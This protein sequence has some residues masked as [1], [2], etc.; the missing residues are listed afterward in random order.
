MNCELC[1][2]PNSEIKRIQL[3]ACPPSTRRRALSM[4]VSS[5]IGWKPA[6]IVRGGRPSFQIFSI[7]VFYAQLH[8]APGG[9]EYGDCRQACGF[10]AQYTR[11]YAHRHRTLAYRQLFF[12]F[13][14]PTFGPDHQ[15]DGL[16][17]L[18]A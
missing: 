17:R 2:N 9:I 8:A 11:P 15:G 5:M 7:A 10:G 1:M 16:R 3:S 14:E 6:W 18:M 4:R 12:R 13:G